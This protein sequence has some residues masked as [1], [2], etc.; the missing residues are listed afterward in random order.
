MNRLKKA[1]EAVRIN[2]RKKL[3]A[4]AA[5]FAI[6][7]ESF[8]DMDLMWAD[9]TPVLFFLFV[10]LYRKIECEAEGSDTSDPGAV[11]TGREAGSLN[12]TS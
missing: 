8:I 12:G 5:V 3:C 1:G 6:F 11:F 9:Y 7:I 4:I 10:T 2:D